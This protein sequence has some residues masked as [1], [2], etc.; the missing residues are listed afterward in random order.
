VGNSIAT[1][2]NT[3]NRENEEEEREG[4]EMKKEKSEKGRK[5][6]REEKTRK[7]PN[8]FHSLEAPR[9]FLLFCSTSVNETHVHVLPP[10]A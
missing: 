5:N 1:K 8:L 4:K 7:K 6:N 2:M 3:R 9:C 10:Q